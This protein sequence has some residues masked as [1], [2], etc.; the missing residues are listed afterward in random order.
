MQPKGIRDELD[1]ICREVILFSKRMVTE[2][3]VVG[4]SGNVSRRSGNLVAITPSG[5]DYNDLEPEDICLVDIG[6]ACVRSKKAPSSELQLHLQVYDSSPAEAVVHT[7][8][9]YATALSTLSDHVPPIHY[10]TMMLGGKIPVAPYATFGTAELADSI[11]EAIAGTNSILLQN[12]GLVTIGKDLSAAYER[13]VQLEWMCKV[14][15]IAK[16]YG[17]P[18]ILTDGELGEV[19][20]RRQ[21]LIRYRADFRAVDKLDAYLQD[22]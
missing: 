4:T 22:T 9:P 8:S 5:V 3:L 10:I 17:E 14:Y 13:A 20:A 19:A 16:A 21:E 11:R 1:A 7:H 6:G 2:G 15:L 12:H 18:K